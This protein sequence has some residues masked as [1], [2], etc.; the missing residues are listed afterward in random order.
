MRKTTSR[1]QTLQ[2]QKHVSLLRVADSAVRF[3]VLP[4]VLPRPD[5]RLQTKANQFV[6]TSQGEGAVTTHL[7]VTPLESDVGMD[8]VILLTGGMF[9][10][11][12]GWHW[13]VFRQMMSAG[14]SVVQYARVV[15]ELSRGYEP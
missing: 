1:S 9:L 11:S 2:R 12:G 14:Q 8:L 15:G 7:R 3:E 10:V 5:V 4:Q 6:K 13:T